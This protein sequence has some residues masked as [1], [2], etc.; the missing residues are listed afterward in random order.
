ML[1]ALFLFLLFFVKIAN[2]Q[3]QPPNWFLD[4]KNDNKLYFFIKTS[5]KNRQE[6]I[7]NAEKEIVK[8][9]NKKFK[10]DFFE[11]VS[12]NT[13]ISIPTSN[14]EKEEKVRNRYYIMMS[15]QK[16]DLFIHELNM[17]E[18][19]NNTIN[20]KYDFINDKN[21]FTKLE[22]FK[23]LEV[24]IE[25]AKHKVIIL[26]NINTDFNEG[27]FQKN[28]EDILNSFENFKSSMTIKIDFLDDKSFFKKDIENILNDYMLKIKDFKIDEN[29][30]NILKVETV[31]KEEKIHNR[32]V[33]NLN[34][35]FRLEFEGNLIKYNSINIQKTSK[36]SFEIAKETIEKSLKKEILKKNIL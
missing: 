20:Q 22:V 28:Y 12:G 13:N 19:L 15:V 33:V 14:V 11:D 34:I 8:K 9:L 27:K 21:I 31:L 16:N 4:E 3:T 29:S 30:S 5:G 25:K 18:D 26:K 23:D 6:A 32:F 1:K 35:F 17:F 2:G 7:Q 24:L 10:D 36:E